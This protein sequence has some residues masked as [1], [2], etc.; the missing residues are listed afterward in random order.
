MIRSIHCCKMGWG[1][2]RGHS[3]ALRRILNGYH[4]SF[5]FFKVVSIK[6]IGKLF[7]QSDLVFSICHT[8]Y[9]QRGPEIY[10]QLCSM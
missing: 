1:E 6:I 3:H 9:S 7:D 5:F 10:L 2:E 8:E 4:F